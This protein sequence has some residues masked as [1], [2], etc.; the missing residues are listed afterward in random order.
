MS[1]LINFNSIKSFFFKNKKENFLKLN[2][3]EEDVTELSMSETIALIIY[4]LIVILFLYFAINKAISIG[5]DRNDKI[6]HV[7]LAALNP[8]IYLLITLIV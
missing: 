5:K 1:E 6:L 7:F 4:M 3:E 8:I 2:H